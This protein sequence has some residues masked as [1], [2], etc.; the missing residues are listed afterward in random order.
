MFRSMRCSNEWKIR[1]KNRIEK[2]LKI[3]GID[4]DMFNARLEAVID[5]LAVCKG[6]LSEVLITFSKNSR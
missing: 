5:T 4:R 3:D 2:V 1:A 6:D